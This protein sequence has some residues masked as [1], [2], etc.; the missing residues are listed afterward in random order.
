YGFSA[1]S[2]EVTVDNLAPRITDGPSVRVLSAASVEIGWTTNFPS[3]SR[4]QSGDAAR[5]DDAPTTRHRLTLDALAPDIG[6]D[7]LV[8]S[9]SA[10]GRAH[11][12]ARG[13]L[14]IPTPLAQI[15]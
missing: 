10:D 1:A 8:S 13:S 6:Q 2:F 15:L 12:E 3:T 14:L 9:V 4:L 5:G 7:F 11:A